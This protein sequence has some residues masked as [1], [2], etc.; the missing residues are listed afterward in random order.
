VSAVTAR[1]RPIEAFDNTRLNASS[2]MISSALSSGARLA[3]RCRG[4]EGG[5]AKPNQPSVY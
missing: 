3:R 4:E 5:T 1:E 2:A